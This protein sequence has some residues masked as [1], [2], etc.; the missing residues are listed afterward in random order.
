MKAIYFVIN[1]HGFW[2]KALNLKEARKNAKARANTKL[3][4]C[5]GVVRKH[6]TDEQL[7]NLLSCFN[8]NEFGGISLYYNPSEE[9]KKMVDELFVGWI[10]DDSYAN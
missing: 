5:I 1:I 6:A 10:T 8:V 2:G 9:D 4:I 7:A 3:E